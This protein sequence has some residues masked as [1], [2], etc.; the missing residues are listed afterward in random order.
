MRTSRGLK[1]ENKTH[2]LKRSIAEALKNAERKDCNLSD[3]E[4]LAPSKE[5]LLTEDVE[6]WLQ[7]LSEVFSRSKQGAKKAAATR[8]RKNKGYTEGNTRKSSGTIILKGLKIILAIIMFVV[9]MISIFC[10]K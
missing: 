7:H 1:W 9:K 6:M 10:R 4:K 3:E 5:T 2:K 8:R